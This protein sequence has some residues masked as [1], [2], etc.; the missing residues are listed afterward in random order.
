MDKF[1]SQ[2]RHGE[3]SNQF[4]IRMEHVIN[5]IREQLRYGNAVTVKENEKIT[6][7]TNFGNFAKRA[8][9]YYFH[10][11]MIFLFN[12]IDV[13]RRGVFDY[14]LGLT[15]THPLAFSNFFDF[16]NNTI[17][18]TYDN[19]IRPSTVADLLCNVFYEMI[20]IISKFYAFNIEN[21]ADKL[22]AI[23]VNFNG[24]S[25]DELVYQ[26]QFVSKLENLLIEEFDANFP[27]YLEVIKQ[28]D[29]EKFDE[30]QQSKA[31]VS[32]FLK[33]FQ[34]RMRKKQQIQKRFH[35]PMSSVNNLEQYF[36]S[37]LSYGK[38]KHRI[39][40]ELR[41]LRSNESQINVG[42]DIRIYNNEWNFQES[43]A[44]LGTYAI[45]TGF[46]D[47]FK[48][49]VCCDID[50]SNNRH[51]ALI[52]ANQKCLDALSK[53][54]FTYFSPSITRPPY[55]E[56]SYREIAQIPRVTADMSGNAPSLLEVNP[57]LFASLKDLDSKSSGSIFLQRSLTWFREGH[58]SIAEYSRFLFYWLGLET[59]M[60][61]AGNVDTRVTISIIIFVQGLANQ[62]TGH[63]NNFIK[64]IGLSGKITAGSSVPSVLREI[65]AQ[66]PDT[67]KTINKQL[68]DF[69][70]NNIGDLGYIFSRLFTVYYIYTRRNNVIHEGETFSIELANLSRVLEKYVLEGIRLLREY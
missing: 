48:F 5:F 3:Y 51:D 38:K 60:G 22:K 17:G 4:N 28:L 32:L 61:I 49:K 68:L 9:R 55:F 54:S 6:P 46:E 53:L 23:I 57:E 52:M 10:N 40:L 25:L 43:S 26:S 33:E 20:I 21:F 63:M 47:K 36:C 8:E 37:W 16:Y 27:K 64:T 39:F 11:C 13:T 2:I 44:F 7:S 50:S 67:V 35:Y 12:S 70:E 15:R 56:P 62:H 29:F 30:S 59:M 58:F 69:V 41:N 31:V 34:S 66:D 45:D 42:D 18:F 65:F 14:I 1:K 19:I 24:L